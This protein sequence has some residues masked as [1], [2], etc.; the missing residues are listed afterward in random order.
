MF[1]ID[2][3]PEC[4]G[5]ETELHRAL[6]PGCV[7]EQHAEIAHPGVIILTEYGAPEAVAQTGGLS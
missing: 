4:I 5:A 3:P 2:N 7:V 6:L 1:F